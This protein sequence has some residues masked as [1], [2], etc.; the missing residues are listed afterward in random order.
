MREIERW[1]VV[2]LA[3]FQAAL[4]LASGMHKLIVPRRIEDVVHQF[5][6]VPR[7]L[8]AA[9]A[10]A[11]AAAELLAGMMLW[12]PSWRAAGGMLAAFMW[13]G[14]L[15]LIVRAIARGRR[16]VDCGCSFG[17]AHHALGP[18]P[19][20]RN[21]ALAAAAAWVAAGAAA[22]AAADGAG[23]I[24]GTQLLASLAF[25][26]LYG[27]LDQVMTLMPLPAGARR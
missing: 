17:P 1:L 18:Y 10:T 2:Q 24:S 27:A 25:L 21:A 23:W 3:A 22:G 16:N 9:A 7:R 12:T 4:L 14:Y 6:G 11:A 15:F 26:A 5:A 20:I 19:V 8:A 13:C